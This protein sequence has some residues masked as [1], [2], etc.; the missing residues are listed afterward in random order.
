MT[1]GDI[2]WYVRHRPVWALDISS[3]IFDNN[4]IWNMWDPHYLNYV[5]LT[6]S[7][8]LSAQIMCF[9]VLLQSFIAS[10]VRGVMTWDVWTLH[11]PYS[12]LC[13]VTTTAPP[14]GC[15]SAAHHW[16]EHFRSRR[17]WEVELCPKDLWESFWRQI[18]GQRFAW[19]NLQRN[20]LT[21]HQG[22]LLN[23]GQI[24][25]SI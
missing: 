1:S 16:Y 8:K 20:F 19:G 7:F 11:L 21:N 3:Q 12:A 18:W 10:N 23:W 5:T 17:Y 22:K 15:T 24:E 6:F 13:L 25:A 4:I 14:P 2:Y 9:S